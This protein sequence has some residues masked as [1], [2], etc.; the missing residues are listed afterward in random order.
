MKRRLCWKNEFLPFINSVYLRAEKSYT[1]TAYMYELEELALKEAKQYCFYAK[2][3]GKRIDEKQFDDLIISLKEHTI[4][5]LGYLGIEEIIV[6]NEE[7]SVVINENISKIPGCISLCALNDIEKVLC[8][9]EN[10]SEN[11]LKIIIPDKEEN[12][13]KIKELIQII[14]GIHNI[15][16]V[17]NEETVA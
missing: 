1:L 5:G 8:N 9:R 16:V 10:I 6:D 4:C 7:I 13:R 2:I 3:G 17:I 11:K 15:E 14:Q 12:G